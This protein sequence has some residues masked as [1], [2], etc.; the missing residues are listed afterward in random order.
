LAASG[1]RFNDYFFSEPVALGA[2]ANGKFGIWTPPKCAGLFCVLATDP[3]WAPKA[4]QPLY[5]GEFGNNSPATTFLR[6]CSQIAEAAGR[7]NL[8]GALSV[9]VLAM[10][11]STTQQRWALRNELIWAYNPSCQTD[12]VDRIQH[13]ASVNAPV[14]P[15]P[16]PRRRIGFITFSEPTA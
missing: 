8:F 14:A 12:F 1:I 10:P 3:D 5:F 2:F 7:K 13:M 16:S 15:P 9:S 4:L 11:F 6:D